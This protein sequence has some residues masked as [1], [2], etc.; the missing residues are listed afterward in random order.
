MGLYENDWMRD[1]ERW[2][3]FEKIQTKSYYTLKKE[4]LYNINKKQNLD[5]EIHM[6]EGSKNKN[7]IGNSSLLNT[8]SK[9]AESV[10]GQFSRNKKWKLEVWLDEISSK[11]NSI[12]SCNIALKRPKKITL[13]A[14][15]VGENLND[16]I[17]KSMSIISKSVQR[18]ENSWNMFRSY[19]LR[20]SLRINHKRRKLNHS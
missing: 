19:L 3:F 12:V 8:T 4:K 11:E 7:H 9:Y 17:K 16:T 5:V 13:Y 2:S 18:E 20:R 15:E 10:L 1:K 14:I 6:Q